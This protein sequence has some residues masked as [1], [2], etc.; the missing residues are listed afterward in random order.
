MKKQFNL[1]AENKIQIFQIWLA[2]INWTLG[3]NQLTESELEILSYFLYYNDKYKSIQDYNVR[4]DLLFS[5]TVKTKI[6]EEFGIST[7]KMETYLNKL[8][9]KGIIINNSLDPKLVIYPDSNIQV[10]F[11]CSLNS[12]EITSSIQEQEIRPMEEKSPVPDM[13]EMNGEDDLDDE[14]TEIH[15]FSVDPFTKYFSDNNN[16]ESWM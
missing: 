1:K 16:I 11:S 10:T 3:K 7:H 15:D 12:V 6:K 14:N 4:M 5:T 8:R 13:E 2:S 9:K